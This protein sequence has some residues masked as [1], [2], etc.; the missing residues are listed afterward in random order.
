MHKSYGQFCPVALGAEIFAERWTPLI[1]RELLSGSRRFS[2][3]QRGLPGISRN[4]LTQRLRQLAR[5]GLVERR[6]GRAGPAYELT[7]PGRAMA[8]VIDAL[9]K[10]GYHWAA[11][12]LRPELLNADLLM[13]FLR[14]RV[15]ADG[16]PEQRTVVR[17]EFREPVPQRVFWLVLQR[18]GADLCVK[19]PG[20]GVD[21]EVVAGLEAM[22][23]VY[24][25]HVSLATAVRSGDVE[26]AGPR[27]AQRAVYRWLGISPFA[28]MPVQKP[29]LA[30]RPA[31]VRSSA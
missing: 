5:R 23:R 22:A 1:V 27:D 21:L 16:L 19:D 20:F 10:W 12:D 25:G 28:D 11:T 18:P 14:R 29:E 13:W 15:R 4:L 2:D 31:S 8:P 7:E 17:F 3:L 30:L 6:A 9:G 26:L 24:L